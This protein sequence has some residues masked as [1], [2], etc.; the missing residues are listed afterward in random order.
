MNANAKQQESIKKIIS[1]PI[2][3]KKNLSIQ[4]V[5]AGMNLKNYIE[6]VCFQLSK[7]G[8]F[9]D[10]N[11][12]IELCNTPEAQMRLTG[13]EEEAFERYMETFRR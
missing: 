5:N 2:D 3:V 13:A 12:L 7:Y 4:A 6:M 11:Q 1:L 10:D 9:C 8:E